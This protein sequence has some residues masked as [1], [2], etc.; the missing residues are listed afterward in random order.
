MNGG[1]ATVVVPQFNRAELT[2]A[3]LASLRR[4]ERV[5]WPVV[6]VDDGGEPGGVEPIEIAG[7]ACVRQEHAGVSAAWNLGAGLA[8]TPYLVF[9]NNDTVFRGPVIEGLLKPLRR[10]ALVSGIGM[11]REGALPRDVIARLPCAEFVAGWCFA[12]AREAFRGI[13][14]FDAAMR[15]YW[16]DTDLQC[17][18]LQQCGRAGDALACDAGLPVR[19]LAHRT[20]RA[21]PGRRRIWSEDR[22]AFIRKWRAA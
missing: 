4:Y 8:A 5:R 10:G 17:R 21:V 9:L 19:H 11:R 3:C 14:G 20:A 18:L 22:A 13:G 7:V 15:V 12:V 16:S 6:V 2:R 1:E